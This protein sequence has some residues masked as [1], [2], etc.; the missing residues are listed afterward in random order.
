MR[1]AEWMSGA[2]LC[3][4][5]SFLGLFSACYGLRLCI[6]LLFVISMLYI[7]FRILD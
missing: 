3:G 1:R 5:R 6:E 4:A 7:W 2:V